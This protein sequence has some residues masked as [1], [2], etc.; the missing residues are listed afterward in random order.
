MSGAVAALGQKTSLSSN[1]CGSVGYT[2]A[3]VSPASGRSMSGGWFIT[4]WSISIHVD[5]EYSPTLRPRPDWRAS[6]A[7]FQ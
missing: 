1:S 6:P 4:P 2:C 7:G 5:M 3:K